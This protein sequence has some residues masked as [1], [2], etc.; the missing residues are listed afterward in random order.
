MRDYKLGDIVSIDD[1]N[2]IKNNLY[3][4]EYAGYENYPTE[5]FKTWNEAPYGDD[6]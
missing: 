4:E 3:R 1:V 5:D 2:K 6:D